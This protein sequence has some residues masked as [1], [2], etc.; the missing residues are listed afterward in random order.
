MTTSTPIPILLDVDTGADDALAL[1]L[2]LHSPALKIRAITCVA[3]N[4]SLEN[5]VANTLR[6]LDA[7]DAPAMPVAAGAAQPLI[8]AMRPPFALH[9]DDGMAD[10]NL[11]A[12]RRSTVDEHA[13][14]L[15][16]RTLH[17]S[18]EPLTIVALA[19]L[20]NIALLLRMYP[21]V[22]AKIARI[23]SMGGTLHSPGNT[24]PTGEFNIR[25]DPE[26]AAMVLESGLPIT[27]YPLDP[28]RQVGFNR[29][30]IAEFLAAD[31]TAAQLAGRIMAHISDFM[32]SDWSLIGDAGTVATVIDPAGAVME[33]YPITVELH[34]QATRGYTICDRRPASSRADHNAWWR[35]SD[36]EIDVVASVDSERYRRL[37][38]ATLGVDLHHV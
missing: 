27:L 4:H 9:G 16:R 29:A 21:D 36:V 23:V 18:A 33:R 19:P 11:P 1:L 7:I 20:T 17:E 28:F 12:P 38:A 15:L 34:G 22:A 25:Q 37:F 2:A 3:G 6:L 30:E 32:T 13:V 31:G 14:E 26:A 5:V 8:E 24:S 35:T 10:L